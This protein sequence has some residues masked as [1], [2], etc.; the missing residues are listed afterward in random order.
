MTAVAAIL[1]DKAAHL[2]S[3]GAVI[4][5][6]GT[7]AGFVAK[8]VVLP[9]LSAVLCLRGMREFIPHVANIVGLT[10]RLGPA[11][12]DQL[13]E[14]A[15]F[16][17]RKFSEGLSQAAQY[18]GA[19]GLF[20]VFVAGISEA[21]GPAAYL[22]SNHDGHRL[23]PFDVFDIAEGVC[24]P[25]DDAALEAARKAIVLGADPA[26]VSTG[27]L[28]AMRRVKVA[29]VHERTTCQAG[30]FGQL[31]TVTAEG[32][33]TRVVCTWPDRVGERLKVG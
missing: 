33:T 13:R 17:L 31:T 29:D 9:H 4:N 5:P 18:R 27:L 20:D 24:I 10:D 15:P 28:E 3:D 21:Q 32:M 11:G 14:I 2:I 30:G 19:S 1:T 26:A 16:L 6:D 12:F 7:V 8:Q 25:D 23:E 22:I